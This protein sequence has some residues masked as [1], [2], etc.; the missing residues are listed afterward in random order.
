MP[1]GKELVE[2]FS[3]EPF[4][5]QAVIVH[6]FFFF[7]RCY[8]IRMSFSQY[9]NRKNLTLQTKISKNQVVM[10]LKDLLMVTFFGIQ[11]SS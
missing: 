11:A 8:V 4:K 10:L 7:C 5:I 6:V 2:G 9:S 1:E 3:R